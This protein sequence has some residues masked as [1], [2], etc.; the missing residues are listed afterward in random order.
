[1]IS[2]TFYSKIYFHSN[3]SLFYNEYA[4]IL[5]LFALLS[6]LEMRKNKLPRPKTPKKIKE[7]NKKP[8]DIFK[9]RMIMYTDYE[10]GDKT[11]PLLKVYVEG[12]KYLRD[13]S[14]NYT[15]QHVRVTIENSPLPVGSHKVG[16]IH[17]N[18]ANQAS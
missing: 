12:C 2:S 14:K 8:V 11:L 17:P 10:D 4:V 13:W 15:K 5:V 3:N 1:M 9:Q 7:P 6:I 18:N 16:I